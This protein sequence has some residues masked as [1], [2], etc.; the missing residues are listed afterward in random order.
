MVLELWSTAMEGQ[1]QTGRELCAQSVLGLS[2]GISVR[3]LG[4]E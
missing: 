1:L 4:G 3:K 2:L